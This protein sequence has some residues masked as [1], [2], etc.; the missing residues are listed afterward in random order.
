MNLQAMLHGV[1][2]VHLVHKRECRDAGDGLAVQGH[3][4]QR[5]RKRVHAGR[6]D[7]AER[8][9]V[10]RAGHHHPGDGGA[11]RGQPGVG[12][13]G[14]GAGIDVPGMGGD[15]G[16]RCWGP[17]RR[18]CGARHMAPDRGLE[19]GP[20]RRVEGA[21]DEG[22]ANGWPGGGIGHDL[23]RFAR[24]IADAAAP[25][26]GDGSWTWELRWT[27]NHARQ[28]FWLAFPAVTGTP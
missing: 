28:R 13:A 9:P 4:P 3:V 1:G 11:R 2:L 10:G 15:N 17:I 27:G 24:T 26:Q 5:C 23:C 20:G 25:K 22:L 6:G 21:G 14:N 7:A 16:L 18:G 8:H 12:A 19:F